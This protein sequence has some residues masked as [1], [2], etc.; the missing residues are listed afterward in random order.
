MSRTITVARVVACLLTLSGTAVAA[1]ETAEQAPL[2]KAGDTYVS[3][4]VQGCENKCPS[5]EIY[6]FSNGRMTF[7]SNNQYTAAK[8]THYKSG[9]ADIYNKISKYL[10]DSGAFN[11]PAECTQK[12]ADTSTATAQASK[13]S[14]V[15]TASWSSACA[16]QREKGRSVVKV[17]VNQ[18]GMWRLIR[19][20]TR[21]WEKYWED[22]EMTGRENVSQ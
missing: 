19:S 1:A 17:F 14:Q 11:T 5:F 10:A 8:G 3:L 12:N 21:Y 7:R 4:Q 9:M 13:D 20:D 22:P 18:T 15:Q 16:E 6:V 2:A